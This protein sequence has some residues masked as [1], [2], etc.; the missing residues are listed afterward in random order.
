MIIE[1]EDT[2]GNTI[3][4]FRIIENNED[5]EYEIFTED[6]CGISYADEE[7]DDL[8]NTN[9]T[10]IRMQLN[11]AIEL[12][13]N[14]WIIDIEKE[15][16]NFALD[17]IEN[18]NHAKTEDELYK[19]CKLYC[20]DIINLIFETSKEYIINN[21]N[22]EITN[23]KSVFKD[24]EE[25]IRLDESLNEKHKLECLRIEDYSEYNKYLTEI[26]KKY[27]QNLMDIDINDSLESANLKFSQNFEWV[28]HFL[29]MRIEVY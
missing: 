20:E 25:I 26:M 27:N 14:K 12:I 18:F 13:D 24:I 3:A 11:N 19:K 2:L 9:D 22:L 10:K 23:K 29:K 1:I 6:F 15:A 7:I 28:L 4:Y 21:S 16:T 17:E 8:M 5:G